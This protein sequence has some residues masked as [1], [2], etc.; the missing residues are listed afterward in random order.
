MERGE[1]EKSCLDY[2]KSILLSNNNIYYAC[3]FE[4]RELIK[5]M[6]STAKPNPELSK[7][8]DFI[9]EGG[10][11]E[12]FEVTSSHS[13]RNGSTMK[14]EQNKLR[15]ESEVKEN[16]LK[17][18][19]NE[20]PCYEGKTITTDTWHSIHTYED[21]C[22]SFKRSWE[23][24][25]ESLAKYKGNKSTGIF[26]IQYDDSALVLDAVFPDVKTEIYYGDLLE[27]PKYGGYRLTHDSE[28]LEYIYQFKDKIHYVAFFNNDGF[29]GERCEIICVENIP[30]ILKIVKEKYRF[31]CAMIGTAHTLYGIS[32]PNQMQKGNDKDEQT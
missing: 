27:Q 19:M 24:H 11:I 9:C 21:F 28:M 18:E 23:H 7:F 31:H 30:E 2:I 25:I 15:K 17:A 1:I 29:H 14:R 8:P 5:Q 10:F 20:T 3:S 12:H 26:M 22:L 4:D 6:F 16:A 32:I 13:N